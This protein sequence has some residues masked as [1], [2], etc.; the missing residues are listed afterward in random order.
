M[1]EYKVKALG[2]LKTFSKRIF[3]WKLKA[4]DELKW[5]VLVTRERVLNET[6]SSSSIMDSIAYL[7]SRGSPFLFLLLRKCMEIYRS[8]SATEMSMGAD[9]SK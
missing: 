4:S 3:N 6:G 7:F 9:E 5:C 2:Y 8:G 1:Q